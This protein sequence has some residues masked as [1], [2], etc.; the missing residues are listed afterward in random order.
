MSVRQRLVVVTA[1]LAVVVFAALAVLVASPAHAASAR[2]VTF[3]VQPATASGPDGRPYFS[4]GVTPG[5]SVTDHA[6]VLNYSDVPLTLQVYAT[7]AL[8]TAAGGLTLLPAAQRPVDTGAWLSL[9]THP[10]TVRVPA[11]HSGRP[12]QVLVPFELAVPTKAAPGD[13]VGGIVVSLTTLSRNAQGAKVRLDQRIASRVYVRVAGAL[14]PRLSVENVQATYR[15]TLDPV[16]RGSVVVTYTVRNTGNVKLAGH[17]RVDV[18]GLFADVSAGALPDVGL[19]LPGGTETVTA[20]V[21]GVL[22]TL[23]MTATVT[24]TP[25]RAAA[26]AD[27]ALLQSSGSTHLAAVPWSALVLLLLLLLLLGDGI[28]AWLRRRS[29][30]PVGSPEPD[31]VPALTRQARPLRALGGRGAAGGVVALASLVLLAPAAHADTSLPYTDPNAVGSI[32]LCDRA[33]QPVTHGNIHDK[34]FVWRA[35]SSVAAAAPYNA[36]GRTATLFAYQPRVETAPGQW[37][38]E[39]VTASAKYSNPAYPMAQATALDGSLADY[40]ADFPTMLDGLV[41]LR[42]YLGA[43]GQPA[44][45]LKYA[46]TD[47]KVSGD[48]WTVARGASVSCTTGSAV[49]LEALLPAAHQAAAATTTPKPTAAASASAAS[50]ASATP[51]IAGVAA[52]AQ[53]GTVGHQSGDGRLVGAL[54]LIVALG[55]GTGVATRAVIR[56]RSRVD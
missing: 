48:T 6:A 19:L 15:G 30:P 41:Q 25:L 53:T 32:G 14:N 7:D 1:C 28:G 39:L 44:Y 3:G 34:P 50:T 37:S 45:T 29:R 55:L 35:V 36:S 10:V 23:W 24:V 27:P 22:P 11:R 54:V 4:Y 13:H 38:G 26:E 33:G 21:P 17:Q 56:N 12:G 40:L 8:N 5:A 16:G 52:A 31:K 46:A 18:S 47:L 49:S 51:T 9:G 20:V 2:L 42:I 43:P